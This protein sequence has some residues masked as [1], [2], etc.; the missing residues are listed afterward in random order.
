MPYGKMLM[1]TVYTSKK[2]AVDYSR[3]NGMFLMES[4]SAFLQYV[5]VNKFESKE[6]YDATVGFFTYVKDCETTTNLLLLEA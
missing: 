2:I 6:V 3:W 4:Q 5:Q 1:T